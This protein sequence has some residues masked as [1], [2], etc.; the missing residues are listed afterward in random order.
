MPLTI[1]VTANRIKYYYRMNNWGELS[2]SDAYILI[3]RCQST[4]FKIWA[5]RWYCLLDK[6]KSSEF[7]VSEA[8]NRGVVKLLSGTIDLLWVNW[9]DAEIGSST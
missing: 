9:T 8:A 5:S 6:V 2:L 3:L 7:S 1:P 4:I